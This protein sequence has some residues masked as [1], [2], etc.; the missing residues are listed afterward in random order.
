M[1]DRLRAWLLEVWNKMINK[2]TIKDKLSVDIAISDGMLEAIKMWSLMY[3]DD[4]S[5][6]NDLPYTGPRLTSDRQHS[7][8]LPAAIASEIARS[9]T[10]EMKVEITGSGN[11]ATYLNE[12][13]S[14]QLA[15]LRQQLEIAIAKGGMIFKPYVSGDRVMI[16]YVQADQFFP[17]EFDADGHLTAVIFSDQRVVGKYYYTRL[18]SHTM[19]DQGCEI[20]NRAFRSENPE[21]LGQEV[22]LTDVTAWAD[23]APEA[24]ITGIERP[25]FS[26]F[27]NPSA[28]TIDATSP[29]GVS[30]FS[31]APALIKEANILWSNFL[32]EFESGERALYIDVLA[33]GK[34]ENGKPILPNQRLYKTVESGSPDGEFFEDWSPT[35]RE[36]NILNGLEAILRKVEFVCGLAYGTISDPASIERTATEVASSKQRSYATIVDTQKALRLA[37]EDLVEAMDI[38]TTIEGLAGTGAYS[39]NFQFDDSVV[40]DREGQ[41]NTD[42][43][44]VN[45][46]LISKLEFRMR[47]F[48]EDEETAKIRLEEINAEQP[49][50][51]YEK[52]RF[53]T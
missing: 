40:V 8:N 5:W 12:Q 19:T 28:N 36:A 22:D 25:L 21:V 29:L 23:I 41:I 1:F 31:R 20:T 7:M 34:D 15:S 3:E 37:L 42:M 13:I 48:G 49:Q 2:S 9:T 38:W 6:M 51:P 26:Y 43:R 17:V 18:E 11:R 30:C 4:T 16:D 33:F 44:M 14:R 45:A 35:F 32:W 53:G 50:D 47:N 39:I 46:G 27:R 10:L 52:Q 24:T